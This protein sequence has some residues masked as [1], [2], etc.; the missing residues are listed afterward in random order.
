MKRFPGFIV[1]FCLAASSCNGSEGSNKSKTETSDQSKDGVVKLGALSSKAPADWKEEKPIG[2]NRKYLFKLPKAGGDAEDAELVI[3]FFP[4]GA[5]TVADNIKRWQNMFQPPAGKTIDDVSKLEKFKVGDAS[6]VSLD[7]AG[8]YL[9]KNPPFDPNAKTV[10]KADYRRF[11]VIFE[12]RG[13]TY[14]LT[15]SGPARTMD[16][17]K[18]SF[19]EWLKNFK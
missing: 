2:M 6:V 5:G 16:Q 13:E 12:T 11:N 10:K 15:V 4:E 19:D 8:T 3:T 7:V 18:K 1:L 9:S 17:H 14:Y